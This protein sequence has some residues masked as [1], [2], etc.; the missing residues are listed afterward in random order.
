MEALVKLGFF[1]VLLAFSVQGMASGKN[2][3]CDSLYGYRLHLT[4]EGE[5]LTSSLIEYSDHQIFKTNVT[6]PPEIDL[7]NHIVNTWKF[8]VP[9]KNRVLTLTFPKNLHQRMEVQGV[10]VIYSPTVSAEFPLM[11]LSVE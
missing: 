2:L 6:T 4:F 9:S 1:V 11:C 7:N 10:F 5:L 8:N 3:A